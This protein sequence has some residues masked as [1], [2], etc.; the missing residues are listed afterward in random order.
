MKGSRLPVAIAAALRASAALCGLALA[1]CRS[2]PVLSADAV[3]LDVPSV[4]Q[5][6]LDQCGLV[7]LEA[8]AR[9]WGHAIPAELDRELAALA[10]EHQGLSGDELVAALERAGFEAFVFAGELDASELSLFHH[11]DRGR[12]LLVMLVLEGE[13]HYVLVAGYDPTSRHLVLLD[14]RRGRALI[15]LGDFERAWN[16]A[17]RFTLLALPLDRD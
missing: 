1:A 13:R 17:A 14:G 7:A 5:E 16:A 15:E 11:L 10:R 12:P 3:V 6:E 2:E 8:L 4:R 9:Y